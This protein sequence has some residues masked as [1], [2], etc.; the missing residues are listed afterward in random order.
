MNDVDEMESVVETHAS[1]NLDNVISGLE[2][3]TP[4]LHKLRGC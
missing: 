1:A 4:K 2:L 3:L